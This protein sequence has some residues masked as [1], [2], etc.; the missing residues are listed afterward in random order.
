MRDPYLEIASQMNSL[1]K[2]QKK[3]AQYV[4][5]NPNNI[6][7]QTVEKLAKEVCVS[8]ATVVRFANAL[9]YKGYP[10]LQCHIQN[11]LQRKL[12]TTER[13]KNDQSL[14]NTIDEQIK[15]YIMQDVHNVQ[16]IIEEIDTY[17]FE[18]VIKAILAAENIYIISS[19]S[20]GSPGMFLNYYLGML[21]GNVTHVEVL[22]TD[23]E[24][25]LSIDQ[26]DVAFAIS[27]ARYTRS[28]LELFRYA[29]ERNACT[30][31]LTDNFSSPLIPNADLALYTKSDFSSFFDSFAASMSMINLILAFVGKYKEADNT[32]RLEEL[33]AL[34]LKLNV[35]Y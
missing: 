19:R 4:L 34:W 13:L 26:N 32:E 8:D 2:S 30:I 20:A 35:F 16:S 6:P 7:F 5:D 24:K 23:G 3:V 31:A 12:K 17:Q 28:T 21:L 18:K 10:D 29:K 9:G 1:S 22:E 25:M 14:G 15:N 27:T 33:E 11:R